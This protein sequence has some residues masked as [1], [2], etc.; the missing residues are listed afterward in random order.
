MRG[1]VNS[2]ISLYITD[3]GVINVDNKLYSP[4]LPKYAEVVRGGD[5]YSPPAAKE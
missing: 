1:Q 4:L 5:Q 3:G 2:H